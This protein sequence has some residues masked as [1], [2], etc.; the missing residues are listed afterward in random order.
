MDPCI[1]DRVSCAAAVVDH[2][3]I[4]VLRAH[5]DCVRVDLYWEP[6]TNIN[7]HIIPFYLSVA[8]SFFTI[9]GALLLLHAR[10]DRHQTTNAGGKLTST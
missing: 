10:L 2:L 3:S 5:D 1:V 6:T 7:I 4:F 9:K 8:V